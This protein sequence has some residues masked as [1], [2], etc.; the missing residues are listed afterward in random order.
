[1]YF[2][3]SDVLVIRSMTCLALLSSDALGI[4]SMKYLLLHVL[5]FS[6]VFSDVPDVP[7]CHWDLESHSVT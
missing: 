6:L 2:V 3:S 1:M 5:W 7:L 4:R